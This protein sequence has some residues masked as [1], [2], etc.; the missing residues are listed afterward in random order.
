MRTRS[1]SAGGMSTG[2]VYS[3]AAARDYT[4][5]L[6]FDACS[7]PDARFAHGRQRGEHH[8]GD[9]MAVEHPLRS[10]A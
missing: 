4:R 2:A 8:E 7:D 9:G 6:E 3:I 1:A 5:M 10:E